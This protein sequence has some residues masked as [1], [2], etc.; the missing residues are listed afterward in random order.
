M[1]MIR[2]VDV[3][4]GTPAV[5]AQRLLN[6]PSSE[7]RYMLVQVFLLPD[8]VMRAVYRLLAKAL[9]PDPYQR[10]VTNLDGND[11]AAHAFVKAHPDMTVRAL[12]TA[13]SGLGITRKK[14]WV[15]DARLAARVPCEQAPK[16]VRRR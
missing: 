16:S 1:D 8:G 5:E 13:L 12:V 15:S 11:E 4:G 3:P 9:D 10:G 7:N 6:G 14:T 2:V